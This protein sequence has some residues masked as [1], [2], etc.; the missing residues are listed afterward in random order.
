MFSLAEIERL[1]LFRIQRQQIELS[2]MLWGFI[3]GEMLMVFNVFSLILARLILILIKLGK[4]MKAGGREGQKC[5]RRHMRTCVLKVDP[6]A[7]GLLPSPFSHASSLWHYCAHMQPIV[8]HLS[9]ILLVEWEQ[10][11]LFPVGLALKT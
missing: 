9:F 10:K 1:S 8:G 6:V 2:P 3:C 4:A 7:S 5:S 11:K